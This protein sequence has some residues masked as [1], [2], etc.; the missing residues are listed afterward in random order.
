MSKS[1]IGSIVGINVLDEELLVVVLEEELEEADV[2]LSPSG[3]ASWN[4]RSSF[5]LKLI[6][7]T[8]SSSSFMTGVC[9]SLDLRMPVSGFVAITFLCFFPI[10]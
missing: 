7:T 10:C 5:G 4:V 6:S 3:L 8:S 1:S 2:S 9:K